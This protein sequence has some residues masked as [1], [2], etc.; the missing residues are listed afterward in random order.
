MSER[1]GHKTRKERRATVKA[2]GTK[3]L[4]HIAQAA[5]AANDDAAEEFIAKVEAGVPTSRTLGVVTSS[6]GDGSFAVKVG[7][8]NVRA[9]VRGKIRMP[10]KSHRNPMATTAVHIG[11]SVVMDGNQIWAVLTSGQAS[12]AHKA[13]HVR[14][15][16]SNKGYNF[17]RRSDE[18]RPAKTMKLTKTTATRKNTTRVSSNRSRGWLSFF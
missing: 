4:G 13:L 12:R 10:G 8:A 18:L 6:Y 1:V 9:S 17:N 11:T 15:A 14:S 3:T 7:A 2:A 5:I 16:S